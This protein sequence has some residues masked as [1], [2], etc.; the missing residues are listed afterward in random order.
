MSVQLFINEPSIGLTDRTTYI[1]QGDNA[2]QS[3]TL[4]RGAR[5][6][7]QFVFVVRAG[8][9]YAPTLGTPIFLHEIRGATDKIAFAGTIDDIG[10]DWNVG[11]LGDRLYLLSCVS[12]EQVYDTIF[13]D[14]PAAFFGQTCGAI[15]AAL[16]TTY[17]VGAPVTLGTITAGATLP[18]EV[19]DR[20]SLSSIFDKLANICG[21]I[22]YVDPDTQKLQFRAPTT[23]AA[24]FTLTEDL[25]LWETLQYK[26][27]RQNFRD[28]QTIRIAFEAFAASNEVFQG[29]GAT[30]TF[31]LAFLPAEVVD[32]KITNAI[33][34]SATGTFTGQPSPGDTITVNDA[35]YIFVT[36][37]DNTL[38]GAVDN[39]TVQ[40]LI[41]GSTAAT[42]Q[43]LVDAINA[44]PATR[45]VAFAMPLWPNDACN[46]DAP[47]GLTF[48][49]W[50]KW[51]GAGGNG[52]PLAKSCSHF[53]WS[54]STTQGGMDGVETTL[55][56]ATAGANV[57][58]DVYYTR[59]SKTITCAVAPPAAMSN[60]G[61]PE[62]FL[63]AYLSVTYRRL[64]GDCITVEDTALV[65]ARAAIEHGTGKYHAIISDT[66]NFDAQ[67]G[68]VRAQ[69]ALAAFKVLP[70][71][72]AF[73]TDT[74]F[75]TPG[76]YL[77]VTILSPIGASAILD[78]NWLVQEVDGNLI[79][80]AEQ[81]PL[82][83]GNFRYTVRVINTY[84]VQTYIGF[85]E[86]LAPKPKSQ[87]APDVPR[88]Q[89]T[90][91]AAR[92]IL[93]CGQTVAADVTSNHYRVTL[94][95][96]TQHVG[97]TQV[98]ITAQVA[99]ASSDYIV[100]M[101][102]STD[103]GATWHSLFQSGLGNKPTLAIGDTTTTFAPVFAIQTL[104]D[105]DLIRVDVLQTDSTVFGVELVL[106]GGIS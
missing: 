61:S 74:P 40:V 53:S 1:D 50:V 99:P 96:G 100:D 60:G 73:M 23:V 84:L 13:V 35:P 87:K 18:A 9:S 26:Q 69:Q 67:V 3:F 63:Q 68:L 64:G 30:K 24:P 12:L 5:G 81:T 16:H 49:V 101:L 94:P 19:Y 76:D 38:L 95:I 91:F 83:L 85:W 88:K 2:A 43:N 89:T 34:S 105:G 27:V 14:P 6:T 55:N 11:D 75:L 71:E 17:A 72:F 51:P 66:E 41:G 106:Y 90:P 62:V 78:G 10:I 28:R 36:A 25:V 54:S 70:A 48:K 58:T 7:A 20:D 21:F 15:V 56:V 104:N 86:T 93:P 103:G 80:A 45:G 47:S 77:T 37:I 46:A 92:A 102:R 8:D 4:Q 33:R 31:D 42:L 44:N 32:C 59:G 22:W 82:P 65:A 79:P 39:S 98:S 57:A 52:T 97:L 29:D